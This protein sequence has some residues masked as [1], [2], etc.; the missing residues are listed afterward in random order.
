MSMSD[1]S[2]FGA[3]TQRYWDKRKSLFHRFDEGVHLDREGLY[4]VKPEAIALEVAEYLPGKVVFDAFCGV[5]GSAIGFARKGKRVVTCDLSA[6]RLAMARHNAEIYG[7][8]DRI[9]FIHGDVFAVADKAEFDCAS[10][11][12]A[13]GGPDYYKK[14]RFT[15]DM[16]SPDG[17]KLIEYAQKRSVPFAFCL[18]KNFD[19]KELSGLSDSFKLTEHVVDGAVQFLT[20]YFS[21]NKDQKGASF[22]SC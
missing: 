18:P 15:L 10:F 14:E 7:V 21:G 1:A 6:E 12:P 3:D 11:D 17:R 22:S 9:E 2:P 8:A 16:F 19:L 13:W 20:A 5:G 4:S